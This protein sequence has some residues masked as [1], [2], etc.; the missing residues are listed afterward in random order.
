MASVASQKILHA[1]DTEKMM[2]DSGSYTEIN[3]QNNTDSLSNYNIDIKYMK[4]HDMD[5]LGKM[6]SPSELHFS[7]HLQKSCKKWVTLEITWRNKLW[8]AFL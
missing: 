4:W 3:S 6:P 7:Q 5:R 1:T 2:N 8:M